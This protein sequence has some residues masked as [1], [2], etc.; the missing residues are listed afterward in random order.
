[1]LY[2]IFGDKFL[3]PKNRIIVFDDF[4]RTIQHHDFDIDRLINILIS[5]K[6]EYNNSL[7]LLCN[8]S[9]VI[10]GSNFIKYREK[11]IGK[12]IRLP[13]L[14]LSRFKEYVELANKLN[15]QNDGKDKDVLEK[16]NQIYALESNIR[17]IIKLIQ[18]INNMIKL[19]GD[20]VKFIIKLLQQTD[21][22]FFIYAYSAR[23]EEYQKL[24]DKINIT[25]LNNATLKY[26]I[27]EIKSNL[28]SFDYEF[29]NS[30]KIDYLKLELDELLIQTDANNFKQNV[31]SYLN[32]FVKQIIVSTKN[33]FNL[34]YVLYLLFIIWTAKFDKY[35]ELFEQILVNPKF[36][37]QDTFK[38]VRHIVGSLNPIFHLYEREKYYQIF[39]ITSEISADILIFEKEYCLF[40]R[41]KVINK[42]IESTD[43]V[44]WDEVS[45]FADG[46]FIR[47]CIDEDQ[48]VLNIR[49]ED[50]ND[51]A[52]LYVKSNKYLNLNIIRRWIDNKVEEK[53][54]IKYY[55]KVLEEFEDENSKNDGKIK[56]LDWLLLEETESFYPNMKNKFTIISEKFTTLNKI[57]KD[58]VSND[59]DTNQQYLS[60]VQK[61][62]SLMKSLIRD[63]KEQ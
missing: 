39:A 32:E 57:I 21:L 61:H 51:V 49:G 15:I 52:D 16:V 41:N 45:L 22:I 44:L 9:E 50:I 34:D 14:E 30:L 26:D 3:M 6:D 60:L 54:L 19:D 33:Q 42:F 48:N 56:L 17:L 53:I 59:E 7:L 4:E 55:A 18:I 35:D 29:N 43:K 20:E 36:M 27:E 25:T 10:D 62:S 2:L 46:W 31:I 5:L 11:L 63:Q 23:G 47:C 58:Y 40:Y 8:D 12:I 1:M 37:D 28:E 24:L 13:K 38:P